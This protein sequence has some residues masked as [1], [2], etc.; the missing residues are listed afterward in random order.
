[1][2]INIKYGGFETLF[3]RVISIVIGISLCLSVV[4]AA[5]LSATAYNGYY[6]PPPGTTYGDINND[7]KINL[8]DLILL[9]K[10]LAKWSVHIDEIAADVNV[11][12]KVNLSDLILM[13][14]SLAKWN[15]VLGRPIETTE[16]TTETTVST[17]A[18]PTTAAPTTVKP[19]TPPPTSPVPTTTD[20]LWSDPY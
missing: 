18:P 11:D 10:Y 16:P 2:L 14:K 12:G 17:T 3:K 1:M 19:T 20:D 9:R 15:V 13:R 7:Q 5:T 8:S 6:P 4:C